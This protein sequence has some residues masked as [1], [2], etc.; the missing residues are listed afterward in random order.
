[1]KPQ[2]TADLIALILAGI[3]GVVVITTTIALLYISATNPEQDI[4][5]AG[6]AIGR[7]I[8][9]IVAALVGYMAGRRINGNH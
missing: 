5:R 1:M 3:L 6:E 7:I 4:A 2:N 8:A 9:V